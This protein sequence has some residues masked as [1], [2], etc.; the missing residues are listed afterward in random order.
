MFVSQL[1]L[2]ENVKLSRG[3]LSDE[4]TDT[5]HH[6]LLGFCDASERGYC[7]VVYLRCGRLKSKGKVHLMMAKTKVAPIKTLTIPRLELMGAVLLTKLLEFVFYSLSQKINIEFVHAWTDSTT[8]L[9]WINTPAHLLKSF[10]ANRI[11]QI[12]ESQVGIVWNH[13][14]GKNNPAD[15]GS[16]GLP[17]QQI[18]N[19]DLWW[20]AP[21]WVANSI[22]QWEVSVLSG[23]NEELPEMKSLKSNASVTD[24]D[25]IDTTFMERYSSLSKLNRVIA[26]CLRFIAFTKGSSN[27]I[28]DSNLSVKEINN[29]LKKCIRVTQLAYFKQDIEY[30]KRGRICSRKLRALSPFI[31][32]DGCLRVGG[33][34]NN[35]DLAYN[36]KHPL[37]LPKEAYLTALIVDHYHKIYLHVGPMTL[38]YLLG[39]KYWIL[40]ARSVVRQRIRKCL[41]CT[42]LKASYKVPRMGDLPSPRVVATRPFLHTGVDFGGPFFIKES[43]RRS[44]RSWKAYMCLFVCLPTKA[45]HLELVSNLTSDAF[46]AALER[47]ISRRGLCTDMYSDCGS[48]FVGASR[49]LTGIN[50]QWREI[51]SST[52]LKDNLSNRNIHW[53][54]N[55]PA[56]PHFGGLWEANMKSAKGLLRKIIGDRILSFE[57]LSTVFAKIEAVLN[58]RPLTP[59]SDDPSDYEALTPGHFLIGAPLVGL[60]ESSLLDCRQNR[61]SRWQLVRQITQH[62]WKRWSTEYLNTLQLR[63]KWVQEEENLAVDDLV[64]VKEKH[65]SLLQWP[66]ARVEKV[67][68]GPDNRVRVVTLRTK[69]GIF[70][71]PVNK[72]AKLPVG[73]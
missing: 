64:I 2:L 5:E 22:D 20:N 30:M 54:F 58:S 49:Y 67:H 32:S 10:V 11:A 21:P 73:N 9:A 51:L 26:Y 6:Q 53:H 18:I 52:I 47:F 48:N 28:K 55:P 69:H 25:T 50:R 16:R 71:R 13:I 4:V 43:L 70:K 37:L 19:N 35:A 68:P 44:S 57:E 33:R 72:V 8:V 61:L 36:R 17:P 42:R 62:F 29:A 56:A 23:R 60:P 1:P 45:I 46:I 31:D 24:K 3:A 27:L 34:L 41:I 39:L 63:N 15:S 7:A 12:S 65:A 40:S 14:A 66:L 59:L 38:Q